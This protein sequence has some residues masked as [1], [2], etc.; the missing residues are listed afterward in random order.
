MVNNRFLVL[1]LTMGL[2]LCIGP[3]AWAEQQGLLAEKGLGPG[4]AEDTDG[5]QK[6]PVRVVLVT[7]FEIGEDEGDQAGEFQLWKERRALNE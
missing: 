7:M 1:L 2:S 6:I 4:L 3:T 5:V